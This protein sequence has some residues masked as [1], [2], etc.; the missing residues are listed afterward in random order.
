MFDETK[1][2]KMAKA[3]ADAR[4]EAE[5]EVFRHDVI[6]FSSQIHTMYEGLCESGFNSE[7]AMQIVC[8]A[9][10]GMLNAN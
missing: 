4:K 5:N 6:Q 8:E 9:I 2:E 1:I 3:L 10:R 7:Q